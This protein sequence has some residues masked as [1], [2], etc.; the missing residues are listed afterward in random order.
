ME[1]KFIVELPTHILVHDAEKARLVPPEVVDA[2]VRSNGQTIK[3]SAEWNEDVNSFCVGVKYRP[4][5]Q[6]LYNY[7]KE[8]ASKLNIDPDS[9]NYHKGQGFIGFLPDTNKARCE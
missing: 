6:A 3:H 9:V 7:L 1:K 2:Y 4:T 8:N 5:K